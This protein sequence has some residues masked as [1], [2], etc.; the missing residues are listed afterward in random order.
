MRIAFHDTFTCSFLLYYWL[1]YYYER[2]LQR[3]DEQRLMR[4]SDGD[5]GKREEE[6]RAKLLGAC[7][8]AYG[9]FQPSG[10]S[11]MWSS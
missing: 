5:D 2:D 7:V 9:K 11:E 10:I 4:K 8:I 6:E 3:V 1:I